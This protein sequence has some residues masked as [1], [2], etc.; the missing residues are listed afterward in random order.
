MRLKDRGEGFNHAIVDVYHLTAAIEKMYDL[1]IYSTVKDIAAAQEKA[2]SDY[3]ANA[4]RRGA[5][6]VKMCREACLEVHQ[7]ETLSETSTVR[8][9]SI[10]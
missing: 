10:L 7:W 6:A 4:R 3:E 2:I 8:Q 1:E 9:K 5:S